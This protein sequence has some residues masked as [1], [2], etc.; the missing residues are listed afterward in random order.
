MIINAFNISRAF[1]AYFICT[2]AFLMLGCKSKHQ[3]KAERSIVPADFQIPKS[4]KPIVGEWEKQYP[5]ATAHISILPGGRFKYVHHGCTGISYSEGN[6]IQTGDKISLQS[7]STYIPGPLEWDETIN[8]KQVDNSKGSDTNFLMRRI[9]Q[10][11]RNNLQLD[12]S[13]VFFADKKLIIR[14]GN[15]ADFTSDGIDTIWLYRKTN[16]HGNLSVQ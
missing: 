2:F 6:W 9:I 15:L 13:R 7:D 16:I 14:D 1:F 5:Y 10:Q 11:Q 4:N 12:S 8:T 3:P